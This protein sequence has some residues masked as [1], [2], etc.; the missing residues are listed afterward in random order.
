MAVELGVNA[1]FVTTV[2]TSD[3][4]GASIITIDNRA[5]VIKDTTPLNVTKITEVGWWASNAT[6]E[7][8]YEVGLYDTDGWNGEGEA[9]TLLYSSTVNAKGTSAGWKT[10]AVDWDI[11]A[12]S[13]YWIGLQVDNTATA[14]QIDTG[15]YASGYD[16]KL[17][18]TSLTN[19]F[20]G[21][22]IAA[23]AQTL[24]LY[25]KVENIIEASPEDL[26]LTLTPT[27]P[28]YNKSGS[29]ILIEPNDNN[30]TSTPND[31]TLINST[32]N[33][34]DWTE[35]D[36]YEIVTVT[37]SKVSVFSTTGDVYCTMENYLSSSQ[38][39]DRD[40][41]ITTEFTLNEAT[42][43][44]S[45]NA[46][47]SVINFEDNYSYFTVF[48]SSAEISGYRIA[49]GYETS[50]SALVDYSVDLS[51]GTKYYL[52][53]KNE[54]RIL[55]VYIRT[56]SHTGTLI[57]TVT[58]D[59]SNFPHNYQDIHMAYGSLNIAGTLDYSIEN[60]NIIRAVDLVN[61]PYSATLFSDQK[62]L[63]INLTT[64]ITSGTEDYTITQNK[65]IYDSNA[66]TGDP[67]I[68]KRQSISGDFEHKFEFELTSLTEYSFVSPWCLDNNT[69]NP[70]YDIM[71]GQESHSGI[72]LSYH[73]GDP[74]YRLALD[75]KD[76]E[77]HY[78]VASTNY[79]ETN[80]RLYLTVKREEKVLTLD[81]RHDNHT[82]AP[83]ETLTVT[84]LGDV[85]PY[86]Y[87]K[88]MGVMNI[89]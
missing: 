72:Y 22:A 39:L 11:E 82:S 24:A 27:A 89:S 31:P 53:I 34:L 37:T 65:V 38:Q 17:S 62:G 36:Y 71:G 63:P 81:I 70:G 30:L 75:L 16:Y 45:G 7:A 64:W 33:F 19:P 56:G 85:V 67:F 42:D 55:S 4:E 21:G 54:S 51:L 32:Q 73:E 5:A 49:L 1:G 3:P 74:G 86:G 15:N 79:Y 87:L 40:F 88:L 76:D 6:E 59:I 25:A 48:A 66:T 35:T 9:G 2:S 52:E 57:D 41:T 26:P 47:V 61:Y 84:G 83:L 80:E 60:V 10:A 50:D 29:T 12:S 23:P 8:N 13:D 20:N 77:D 14:T 68:Y 18:Q 28:F 58:M 43:F 69:Y 46:A 44:G 78:G